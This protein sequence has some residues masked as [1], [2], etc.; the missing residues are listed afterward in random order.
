MTLWQD[1][2]YAVRLLI[3][4]RWFTAIAATA[5]ALG[6]GVNAT[7][8]TLVN[9]VLIRGLPFE[10][11]ERIVSIAGTDA[12]GRQTGVSRLDFLDWSENNR[13]FAGLTLMVVTSLNVS[14]PEE[15]G[16]P[17]EQFQGTYNSANMF[18]LIGQRPILGRDF[19]PEDDQVGAPATVI[20]GY[21]LWKNRYNS[22]PAILTRTIRVNSLPV[23]VIGVMPADMKFPFNNDLWV[24]VSQ[25]APEL[26]QARRNA[27]NF[28]A[29]GRLADGVTL[30]QAAS[31]IE[32]RSAQLARDYPD[33]NKDYK[34]NLVAFNERITGPQ[35]RLIFFSLMGAVGFV[36]LIACANVANLLLGRA[37]RRSREIAVRVS[38]GATRWRI[39]RQLLVESVLLSSIGG[40]L[41]L[42]LAMLGI[43]WFDA[44]VT[45]DI[46]KP[47]WMTFTMDPIVFVFLA[48]ICLAT[49]VL[50]GLAP[51]LHVSKT[52]LNEVMKDGGG[53]RGGTGGPR[54][55]RWTS[56]LIVVEIA[57]TL[58]LLAG[59]GFMMRSFLA[60]YRMDLGIDSSRLLTMRLSL[61]LG[62]YPKPELR[63]LLFQHL[64]ERL[65]GVSAIQASAITSNLP[66]FG[67]FLR[68]LTVEGRPD[69][70][71]ERPPE[72]T[73]VSVSTGYFDTLGVKTIR[74]R[75]FND[76]DGTPGHESVLVNQ[77]F[78]AMHFPG[79]DP[80]GQRIRLL[81][82]S[83]A[84]VYDATPPLAATIVGVVPTVRQRNF[85]EPD[86]DPVAYVPYRTDPQRFVF[87]VVRG[88]G[89]PAALT[90]L[91]REH[92]R[93]VEP[94]LP[95]FGILTLDQ[96][97]A[98]QRFSFR[99]FG[100]M[101]GMF[102]VI[103]L[104]LSAVGLYAVTAY[105]VS[106]R[107]AEIGVRMALGA[108]SSQVLWLMMRQ[109]L[110]QLAIGLPIGVAGA[111]GVGRLLQSVLA[112]TN[113]RDPL[114]VAGIAVVMMV[115]SIAAC[116]WPARRAT[117]LDPVAALRND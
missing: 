63:T 36:L 54:A 62:R 70:P 98:Q 114:T 96:I 1:L 15:G 110:W 100:S 19:R 83:P 32:T 26:R 117:R 39:V 65:R 2:R 81:D 82:A 51:A 37:A 59:A 50:F 6:I 34:P 106:Q 25:I 93:A 85:Q 116:F 61:P 101:F 24:P 3:K 5:L 88:Q 74:G 17:P 18:H 27:R 102:A 68:Q 95:L 91:V 33:T 13:A 92:M 48:T 112:Q 42:G 31:E 41:G 30:A 11:P 94:D 107:T 14:D 4:D 49:G 67:G 104:V 8:F 69:R 77:R 46:G 64:D 108:Q 53:G 20:L 45:T 99:V 113:G 84:R 89:D 21:S 60:L 78:A 12:R 109:A 57:L 23:S 44:Q 38:L 16:R 28:Q 73:V 58:V 86:P 10:H 76:S 115:V 111:F 22:D 87:L 71:G 72:V 35:L 75:T 43:K 79:E 55:R 97:L 9:A 47:Y 66:M 105:A 7:V 103:A 80:V 56:A 52:D 40:V 29:I 90:G